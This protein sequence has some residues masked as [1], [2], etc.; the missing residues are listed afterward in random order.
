MYRIKQNNIKHKTIYAMIKKWNQKNMKE[1]DRR[2][3]HISSILH[4]IYVSS[5]NV[6]HPNNVSE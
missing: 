2:K 5:N 1:C 6:R 3:S 4:M